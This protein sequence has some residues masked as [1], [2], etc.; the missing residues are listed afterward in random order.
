MGINM[1]LGLLCGYTACTILRRVPK[2]CWSVSM[3]IIAHPTKWAFKRSGTDVRWKDLAYNWHFNSSQRGL[4]G[5][6]L[7]LYAGHWRSFT[8][9]SNHLIYEPG[10][11]HSNAGIRLAT[12]NNTL[13]KNFFVCCSIN[14][15][16]GHRQNLKYQS[17]AII[18]YSPNFTI[19]LGKSRKYTPKVG[20][21]KPRFPVWQ[22]R[23]SHRNSLL[24]KNRVQWYEFLDSL[25][26]LLKAQ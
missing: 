15:E 17:H 12:K 16:K 14:M 4:M 7:V 23:I 11:G 10:F 1:E 20:S 24:G 6:R 3:G 13:A 9:N 19:I 18:S 5:L 21:P 26:S 8:T 22:T 2:R 25:T